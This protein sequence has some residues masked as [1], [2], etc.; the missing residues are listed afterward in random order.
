M[1]CPE[2][3]I[4]V[5]LSGSSDAIGLRKLVERLGKSVCDLSDPDVVLGESS[6]AC[7]GLSALRRS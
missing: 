1:R 7:E 6:L 3:A 4:A 2:I 5:G